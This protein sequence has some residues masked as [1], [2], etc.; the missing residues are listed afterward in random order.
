MLA[1]NTQC[2]VH[3]NVKYVWECEVFFPIWS[4]TLGLLTS[5]PVIFWFSLFPTELPR[6]MAGVLWG[7]FKPYLLLALLR[8]SLTEPGVSLTSGCNAFGSN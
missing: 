4:R 2:S 5:F 7:S 3:V 6:I 1:P 8:N